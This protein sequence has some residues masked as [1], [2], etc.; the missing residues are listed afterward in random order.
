MLKKEDWVYI[1]AQ[2]EKGVYQKDIARKLLLRT[3]EMPVAA[4]MR[5][6]LTGYDDGAR[7][8]VPAY[9][10]SYS[11]SQGRPYSLYGSRGGRSR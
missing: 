10:I 6:L 9:S 7:A 1:K 3:G 5:Q 2:V 8:R 11:L 4:V